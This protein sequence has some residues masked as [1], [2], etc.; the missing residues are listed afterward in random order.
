MAITLKS[1]KNLKPQQLFF[2]NKL[3]FQSQYNSLHGL[4]LVLI[5]PVNKTNRLV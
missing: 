5:L 3:A 4:F 2:I 1:I